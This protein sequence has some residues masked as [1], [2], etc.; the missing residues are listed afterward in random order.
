M[1]ASPLK[2]D[3]RASSQHV[4]YGPN[5]EVACSFDHLVRAGEQHRREG[6]AELFCRLQVDQELELGGL[7]NRHVARLIAKYFKLRR[8]SQLA[9]KPCVRCARLHRVG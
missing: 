1:S 6:E 5:S 7:I 2:A 3:I 8:R 9:A 4:R